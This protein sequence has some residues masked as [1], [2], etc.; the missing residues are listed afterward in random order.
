MNALSHTLERNVVINAPRDTVFRFFT[1]D[2]RWASWWGAGSTIEPRV[3]GRVY[4]RHPGNVEV[5][6]EVLELSA[7]DAIVLTYGYA[8]GKP[9]GPGES[10]VTIRLVSHGAGTKLTLSHALPSASSRDEHV[11]G[12]RY[13]LALFGNVV[14]NELHAGAAD[15]VDAWFAVWAEPDER[16]RT[17]TL[18]RIASADVRFRDRNSLLDGIDDVLPHIAAAQRFM[19]GIRLE[20]RGPVRHCQGTVLADWAA[21]NAEGTTLM[22]GVNV[23]VLGADGKIESATGLTSPPPTS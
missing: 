23:F 9:F 13:Q 10:V 16:L 1:D 6:G 7:P 11:Q 15:T 8:S 17:D 22:H 4:I 3:G 5:T 14:A 18:T 20:R 19:S 2:A 12:W 21:V